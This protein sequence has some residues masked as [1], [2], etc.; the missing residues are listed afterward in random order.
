MLAPPLFG[1]PLAPSLQPIFTTLTCFRG[2][3]HTAIADHCQH[4]RR[5]FVCLLARD[6]MPVPKAMPFGIPDA[7]RLARFA[8]FDS[9]P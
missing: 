6:V 1:W 8:P 7:P 5:V 9:G 4:D 3:R 2:C